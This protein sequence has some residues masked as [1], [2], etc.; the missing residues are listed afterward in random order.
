M[1]DALLEQA[2]NKGSVDVFRCIKSLRKARP[3]MVQTKVRMRD[4]KNSST[5]Y[6][7]EVIPGY[8]PGVHSILHNDS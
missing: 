4:I 3:N 5:V 7:Q 6:F 8:Q 1:I 2:K